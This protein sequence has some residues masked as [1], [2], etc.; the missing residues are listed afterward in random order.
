M[1]DT[2]PRRVAIIGG[3]I[4]GVATALFLQSDGHDVTIFEPDEFGTGTSSGN[5]GGICRSSRLGC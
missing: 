1:S 5:A 2:A 3:G 4:T